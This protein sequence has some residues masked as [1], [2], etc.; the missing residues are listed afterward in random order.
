MRPLNLI[1]GLTFDFSFAGTTMDGLSLADWIKTALLPVI[2]E[3]IE[4]HDR[5]NQLRRIDRLEIDLGT[6]SQLESQHESQHESQCDS[7]TELVR[8][9][10]AKLSAALSLSLEDATVTSLVEEREHAQGEHF[11]NFLRTG[12]LAWAVSADPRLAHRHLLQQLLESSQAADVLQTV[13]REPQMLIR[14]V[15]QFDSA[16]LSGIARVLFHSWPEQERASALEWISLELLCQHGVE[17][18]TEMRAEMFWR[19]L[20]LKSKRAAISV[21]ELMQSWAQALGQAQGQT[22]ESLLLSY[23]KLL[24]NGGHSPAL[25]QQILLIR[26]DVSKLAHQ[27]VRQSGLDQAAAYPG[28]QNPEQRRNSGDL[29]PIAQAAVGN[30]NNNGG[31]DFIAPDA[32]FTRPEIAIIKRG[33]DAG[34]FSLL[35]PFWHRLLVQAPQHLHAEH[36]QLWRTWLAQ[37]DDDVL[38]DIL[39]A[40]QVESAWVMER[41][42]G[43]VSRDYLYALLKPVLPEW[44]AVAPGQLAPQRV[45]DHVWARVLHAAPDKASQILALFDAGAHM[46][47]ITISAD[48]RQAGTGDKAFLP[49]DTATSH[50]VQGNGQ[51]LLNEMGSKSK[52]EALTASAPEK[53]NAENTQA[54]QDHLINAA[55]KAI[56]HGVA[57]TDLEAM[58]RQGDAAQLAR[59]WHR[60]LTSQRQ[61]FRDIWQ[62]LSGDMRRSTIDHLV[63]QL[64]FEQQLDL[65]SLLQPQIAALLVQ[66][67]KK[68]PA[69]LSAQGPAYGKEKTGDPS[70]SFAIGAASI[71]VITADIME[72]ALECLLNTDIASVTPDGLMKLVIQKLGGRFAAGKHIWAMTDEVRVERQLAAVLQVLND[73]V[74]QSGEIRKSDTPVFS[75]ESGE[76]ISHAAAAS[77]GSAAPA[78]P[79]YLAQNSGSLIDPSLANFRDWQQ[80]RI[81]LLELPMTLGDLR[82]WLNWWLMHDPLHAN[83][84]C[85]LMLDVIDSQCGQAG[86]PVLFMKLV[87]QSLHFDGVLD[88]EALALQAQQQP[89]YRD[90]PLKENGQREYAGNED[91][92]EGE[93][94]ELAG[95]AE[96]SEIQ[97][98]ETLANTLDKALEA[99]LQSQDKLKDFVAQSLRLDVQLHALNSAQL[100]LLVRTWIQ[101]QQAPE[102]ISIL[103][104]AIE[105]KALLAISAHVFF[106]RLLQQL[107]S[108][109]TIDLEQI[110]L[111]SDGDSQLPERLERNAGVSALA[112]PFAADMHSATADSGK[113][114]AGHTLDS[115]FYVLLESQLAQTKLA[116]LLTDTRFRVWLVQWISLHLADG[117][118]GSALRAYENRYRGRIGPSYFLAQILSQLRKYLPQ[119]LLKEFSHITDQ[120]FGVTAVAWTELDE[121]LSIPGQASFVTELDSIFARV[122]WRG[123]DASPVK[124]PAGAPVP[125][126]ESTLPEQVQQSLPQRLANAMLKA[127][128]NLL[129]AIWPEIIDCHA[130]LLAQAARHY[131]RRADLRERLIANT[132]VGMLKELLNAL[133]APV[134]QLVAP[135]LQHDAQC[136]AMLA[137]PLALSEFQGRVLRFA[138][139]QAMEDSLPLQHDSALWMQ[140]L[141]Q[142]LHSPGSQDMSQDQFAQSALAWREVLQVQ[143]QSTAHSAKPGGPDS[144]LQG[145]TSSITAL[146]LIQMLERALFGN[147]YLAAVQQCMREQADGRMED[148]TALPLRQMLIKELGDSYP[149]L[150]DQ[151]FTGSEIS[152]AEPASFSAGE[153]QSLIHAQLAR[154][155]AQVQERFW[156]AFID[157]LPMQTAAGAPGTE[158]GRD[159]RIAQPVIGTLFDFALQGTSS[160]SELQLALFA[161]IS[162]FQAG[163]GGRKRQ[164]DGLLPAPPPKA[165]EP[166]EIFVQTEISDSL[167]ETVAS[168]A[169]ISILLMRQVTLN[170]TEEASIGLLLERLIANRAQKL[171]G[172]LKSAL[173]HPQAID[174]LARIVPGVT[175]A[176]LFALIRPRLAAQLAPMLREVA[177]SLSIAFS[178]TPL[179]LGLDIWRAIYQA[180]LLNGPPA[181][182]TVFLRDFVSRLAELH[183]HAGADGWLKK[184]TERNA[185][186]T[187][188]AAAS[189]ITRDEAMAQLLQPLDEGKSARQPSMKRPLPARKEDVPVLAHG[190]SN[191]SNAGLVIIA[192]YVQRLFN[193][194]NITEDGHFV[195]DEALQRAVHLLQYAVTGEESTPEYQ[196]ML[197]KLLCGAPD[198]LPIVRGIAMTQQERDTIEQM[199][200]GV[201][202]HWSAIGNTSIS[203]L[204]E[205][206][207]RREGNLHFQEEAWR[208]KIPQGSF[209]MLLDRLPWSFS[210]IKFPWMAGPLHVTWR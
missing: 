205:T 41:L 190:D 75:S 196:L 24:E 50:S 91:L 180:A 39:S 61:Q 65:A 170:N 138:F 194:L 69:L 103:L 164:K 186:F 147:Q 58:L 146:P 206:F 77:T 115:E 56:A 199:L 135:I 97:A 89:A 111:A 119:G 84:D 85:S 114:P 130:D 171:Q 169:L 204:R 125:T 54:Q 201:I 42:A 13:I 14:L 167:R 48:N 92:R 128:F 195:S 72:S 200:T 172:A 151:I 17:M 7:Q 162:A 208:L 177:G 113:P 107:A 185:S 166:A 165:D 117:N 143:V 62:Q 160:E 123:L 136:N 174:R 52:A 176:R 22:Q 30:G 32:V 20:L 131:L 133:S 158:S 191:I 4:Q 102:T 203:G 37:F 118:A 21:I 157:V 38:F 33:L 139:T 148:T 161:G 109:E 47:D 129:H 181:S 183:P 70:A 188:W 197:N 25:M 81:N 86:D 64:N 105:E 149:E 156:Q 27:P 124:A 26:Q 104:V 98:Y 40:I 95:P 94:P 137:A 8:R 96:S 67:Q 28:R 142:F 122:Q 141:L 154:H 134:Y 78:S 23:E 36:P 100:H 76:A 34:D 79:E 106:R 210:L 18:K 83:Q 74:L 90:I 121:C 189:S 178:G 110:L 31:A 73:R 12:S 159:S 51:D 60:V 152:E 55:G 44:F 93:S 145:P 182:P 35:L 153:W 108:E 29:P 6:V 132:D 144:S 16:E 57:G 101:F 59:I 53:E 179:T 127:D 187:A 68:L 49:T 2:E 45:L 46:D 82:Q 66:L 3:T 112:T 10:F 163:P 192:P 175:L 87:L 198:G 202:A 168:E 155:D 19:W 140:S 193:L 71:P 120:N 1:H 11:L 63:K 207:L 126:Q 80:Q 9:L 150:T 173:S 184:I 88:M 209:D 5:K 99:A 15:R 116:A 43:L